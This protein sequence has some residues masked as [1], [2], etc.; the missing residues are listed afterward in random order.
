M[1]RVSLPLKMIPNNDDLL[2]FSCTLRVELE[3]LIYTI[4]QS[5]PSNNYRFVAARERLAAGLVKYLNAAVL[6]QPNPPGSAIAVSGHPPPHQL[7]ALL[8][9]NV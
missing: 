9:V 1:M 7:T 8:T 5:G 4:E 6:S 3:N 2:A